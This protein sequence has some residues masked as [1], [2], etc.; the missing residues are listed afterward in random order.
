MVYD[1]VLI[2][3]CET[4][5]PDGH[6]FYFSWFVDGESIANIDEDGNTACFYEFEIDSL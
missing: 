4:Y 2:D 5:D 3:A 1:P 6:E